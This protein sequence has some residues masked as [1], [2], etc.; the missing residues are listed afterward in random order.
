[1]QLVRSLLSYSFYGAT[2]VLQRDTTIRLHPLKRLIRMHGHTPSCSAVCVLSRPNYDLQSAPSLRD[3]SPKKRPVYSRDFP[4]IQ[5]DDEC[6]RSLSHFDGLNSIIIYE[7]RI[8]SISKVYQAGI[9]IYFRLFH[10]ETFLKFQD[11]YYFLTR[12]IRSV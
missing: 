2:N 9:I 3:Y 8:I 1:M 11:Y 4:P 6:K 10:F 12:K 5:Q 7:M